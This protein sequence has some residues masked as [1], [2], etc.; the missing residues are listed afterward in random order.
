MDIDRELEEWSKTEGLN[1]RNRSV[2]RWQES[3]DRELLYSGQGESVR[4]RA[5]VDGVQRQRDDVQYRDESTGT[6]RR[7][8]GQR[9]QPVDQ[10]TFTGIRSTGRCRETDTCLGQPHSTGNQGM[11][12]TPSHFA[13]EEQGMLMT[14]A[15]PSPVTARSYAIITWKGAHRQRDRANDTGR[16]AKSALALQDLTMTLMR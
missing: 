9:K 16:E 10:P 7:P 14:I 3:S 5:G 12:S 1:N 13:G 4:L 11:A 2:A 8:S 15:R 6:G